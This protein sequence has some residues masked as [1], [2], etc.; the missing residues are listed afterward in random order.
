VRSRV[1]GHLSAENL[2]IYIDRDVERLAREAFGAAVAGEPDRFDAAVER[3]ADRGD[4]FT[5]A[6]LDLGVAVDSAALF[7]VHEGQ[8]PDDEQLAD[9]RSRSTRRRTGRASTTISR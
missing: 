1:A 8:R 7:S 6:A 2:G 3:I 4:A 5:R 9:L